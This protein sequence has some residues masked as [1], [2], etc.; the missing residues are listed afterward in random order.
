M[1][2]NTVSVLRDPHFLFKLLQ[3]MDDTTTPIYEQ[4]SSDMFT[5]ADI[6]SIEYTDFDSFTVRIRGLNGILPC[7][8]FDEKARQKVIK[9]SKIKESPLWRV[10][11]DYN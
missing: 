2:S 1:W 11:N 5:M 6:D 8:F 3:I 7:R 10:L 9:C 4:I